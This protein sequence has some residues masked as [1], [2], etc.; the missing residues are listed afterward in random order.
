VRTFRSDMTA[1]AVGVFAVLDEVRWRSCRVTLCLA[2]E[3]GWWLVW[4]EDGEFE[5]ELL[6]FGTSSSFKGA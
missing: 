2:R 4:K 6:R 3:S 5:V 1:F